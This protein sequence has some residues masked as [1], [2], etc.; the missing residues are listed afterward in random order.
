VNA[1]YRYSVASL[2]LCASLFVNEAHAV[3]CSYRALAIEPTSVVRAEIYKG[4]GKNT[5][6]S[7]KNEEFAKPVETFPESSMKLRRLDSGAQC[8]VEGG[9][10]T[11]NAVY[12]S[13]DE[14][15]VIAKEFSGS[16]EQLSFYDTKSCGL[17][18]KIDVS[19]RAWKVESTHLTLGKD[20]KNDQLESCAQQ[21][22]HRWLTNCRAERL[23]SFIRPKA[24][25]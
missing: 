24:D 22:K 5:E 23:G 18:G 19:N 1:V 17:K 6:V 15:M 9:I 3:S 16:N 14:R 2:L 25:K 13:S 10:W 7:F 11:R 20:C 21:S 4:S 12:L 8:E